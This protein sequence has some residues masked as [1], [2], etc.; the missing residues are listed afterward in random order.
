[1]GRLIA[2]GVGAVTVLVAGLVYWR[3][4]DTQTPRVV[5]EHDPAAVGRT[6]GLDL[7]I[8]ARGFPGLRRVMVDLVSQGQRHTLLQEDYPPGGLFS[9]GTQERTLHIEADLTARGIV[10]GPAQVEVFADTHAWHIFSPRAEPQLTHPVTV[11]LTPPGIELLT[12]QHNL[13]LG[14]AG[15]AVVRLSPDAKEVGVEVE[16]YRFPVTRGYFADQNVALALFAVPQDVSPT[17]RPRIRAADEVGNVRMVEV[18]SRIR[19]WSFAD[20]TIPIDDQ[21][22]QRKVPELL[23]TNGLPA[24]ADLVKGY[25]EINR[26]LRR[27]SEEKLRAVTAKSAPEPLWDGPFH[28][29]SNSAP[30]SGFADRRTY[31]YGGQAIDHQVHLG[32]DLASVR[33]APIEAT[34]HGVVVY[35]GNLGI[36]G[37][38]VVIDHGLG[39]FS[40]Y[41]HLSTIGVHVG[42]QVQVRDHL[43]QSGETG[44]AGGDHLHF[45]TMV[46][47]THVDPREWWDGKWIRD[48][49][50]SGLNVLPSAA[51]QAA[52]QRVA[53]P[54]D[55]AADKQ[56]Q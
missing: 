26:N 1:V 53:A 25:L 41:G 20:R 9:R 49:V 42:Q 21:F 27:A 11:D 52:A 56:A 18:P 54:V 34:Q 45:S 16:Q 22:L 8:Q 48:H 17:S 29:Q 4:F 5:L 15:L 35:A 7:T 10:E 3:M 36:Y 28:R 47:G 50:T 40:L 38:T 51:A 37:N 14:G 46:Y 55:Q 31:M 39:L 12:T 24:E 33:R 43:G 13:R 30:M 19:T 2:V 32:F 23:S 44:L 6:A